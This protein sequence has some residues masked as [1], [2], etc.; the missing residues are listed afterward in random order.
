MTKNNMV[1][2]ENK[3]LG[4]SYTKICHNSGLD[5]YVFPKK[6]TT[7]FAVFGTKYGSIDN[8]F[9]LKGEEN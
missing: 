4:E 3:L 8:K 1:V 5:I 9:R 7:T 6:L 2:K